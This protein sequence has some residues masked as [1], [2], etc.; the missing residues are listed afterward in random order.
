MKPVQRQG[1][2]FILH[3]SPVCSGSVDRSAHVGVDLGG[4]GE[5][6]GPLRSPRV[7]AL[8]VI[9]VSIHSFTALCSGELCEEEVTRVG[10]DPGSVR[11]GPLLSVRNRSALL[12]RTARPPPP[13]PSCLLGLE[14]RGWRALVRQ[15]GQEGG[16]IGA[17]GFGVQQ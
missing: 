17:G 4:P 7:S 16:F 1:T 3:P 15:T 14:E 13:P 8:D 2:F 12:S 11:T 6:W 10:V 5:H 9:E